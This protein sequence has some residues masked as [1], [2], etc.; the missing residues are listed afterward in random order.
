MVKIALCCAVRAATVGT[1]G[2]FICTNGV[3]G[4]YAEGREWLYDVA[5][6]QYA[7]EEFP[8]PLARGYMAAECEWG[9][10]QSVF[11]DF[12]KLLVARADVRI[13]VFDG[14]CI[15]DDKFVVMES[16]IQGYRHTQTGDSYL[17]AAWSGNEFEYHVI[18]T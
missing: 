8:F 18:R 5:C 4:Q 13:M 1:N 16:L 11:D 2:L 3:D 15:G 9:R 6:L 12:Q 17:L 10:E 14:T 7:D